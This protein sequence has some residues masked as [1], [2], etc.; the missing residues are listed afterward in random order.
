MLVGIPDST[1]DDVVQIQDQ[2]ET[3]FIY[4]KHEILSP[5]ITGMRIEFG[6][7]LTRFE[8]LKNA[9]IAIEDAR[10]NVHNGIDIKRIFGSIIHNLSNEKR[11]GASTIT[12]QLLKNTILTPEVSY[13][14]KS[15]KCTWLQL[16][17][18]IVRISN[19]GLP[20]TIWLG[21]NYGVKAAAR[22]I[23]AKN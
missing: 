3:N 2:S 16:E 15:R 1:P 22:T 9:F 17:K 4:D 23:L 10:F 13:K 19:G 6:L 11:T 8:T 5:S 12:Q 18:S 14:E 21:S 20:N 7:P